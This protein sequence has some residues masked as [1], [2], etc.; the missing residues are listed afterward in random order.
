VQAQRIEDTAFRIAQEIGVQFDP[1]PRV[2]DLFSGGGCDVSADGRVKLPRERAREAIDSMAKSV[3]IWDR[4]GTGS[5]EIGDGNTRFFPGMTC[6]EVVDPE[7]REVRQS[8][9]EDLAR[10]ASWRSSRCC[11]RT[12]ASRWNTCARTTPRSRR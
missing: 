5:I 8:T 6:I 11:W 4:P 1:D 9:R 10:K 12:R 2:L 7:T 3:Q